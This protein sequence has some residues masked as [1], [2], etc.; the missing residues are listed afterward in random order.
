MLN[1]YK[2]N[3]NA[4]MMIHSHG[5]RPHSYCTLARECMD[6]KPESTIGPKQNKCKTLTVGILAVRSM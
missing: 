4:S 2:R 3:I 1:M 6:V 5:Y